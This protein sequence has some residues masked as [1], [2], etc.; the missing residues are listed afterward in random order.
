MQ[1]IKIDY[2]SIPECIGRDLG[3][4]FYKLVTDFYKD[5]ENTKAFEEWKA[6]EEVR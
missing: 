6:K 4:T 3:R 2:N 1:E 5:P